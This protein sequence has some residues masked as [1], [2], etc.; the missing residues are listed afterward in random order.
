MK[1]SKLTVLVEDSLSA[2]RKARGHE[3]KHGL[4]ILVE[5]PKP[6]ISIMM[7]TGQSPSILL[8]N[9]EILD[10]S[11]EK[12]DAIFLSHSH[13]D[14]TGGLLGILKEMNRNIPV[15]AHPDVL[16]PKF[17]LVPNLEYI[18]SPFKPSELEFSRGILLAG[19][20]VVIAE[21]VVTTGEI[22]RITPY[23]E[24][25]G[26]W[27]V[28]NGRFIKDTL[29]DDQALI[30]SLEDKGLVVVSGCAHAGIINTIR[31][32]QKL[33]G[34]KKIYAVIGGFHLIDCREDRIKTTINDLTEV[35]PD[36]ICP[37]H[38][39]GSKPIRKLTETFKQRCRPLKAGDAFKV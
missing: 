18:G 11:L 13:Y 27:T 3:A 7:D 37:C 21:G 19:N 39:T 38:C 14:R 36:F 10:V 4:S 24:F 28:E 5:I 30:L 1:R 35:N 23:E 15:I 9:M 8:H 26:F 32:A 12:V 34:V 31:H 25:Q 22:E 17:K 6:Q 2:P 16:N 33:M 29:R 20:P